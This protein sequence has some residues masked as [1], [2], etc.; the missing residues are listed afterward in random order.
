MRF[1]PTS[2]PEVLLIEPEPVHDARGFFAR[3][4][5][6][7]EFSERG[8]APRFPQISLSFNARRGTLRGIHL[9]LPPAEEAKLVMCLR[10]AIFDVAVDLRPGSPLFGQ[11]TWQILDEENRRML[12]IPRGFGHG[13]QTLA[14][15]TEVLYFISEFYQP[16][17]ARG[18]R[19]D[20]PRLGIPWPEPVTVISERDRN[21]PTVE[22]FLKELSP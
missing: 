13:F 20:D 18:V 17:L 21:L 11:V 4:I 8:L 1:R 6:E 2:H 19:W 9:Q 10:G 3:L 5:C 14:D 7:R 22:E 16:Q 12:Y 15:N